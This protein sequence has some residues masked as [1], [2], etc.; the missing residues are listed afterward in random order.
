MCGYAYGVGLMFGPEQ[1][2]RWRV[3]RS[4]IGFSEE[5]P[6]MPDGKAPGGTKVLV[7]TRDRD[8]KGQPPGAGNKGFDLPCRRFVDVRKLR[9]IVR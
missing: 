6:P 2:G 9:T 3:S 5:S 7:T 1:G 8:V 4:D